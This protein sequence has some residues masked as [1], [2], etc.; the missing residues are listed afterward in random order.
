MAQ[1]PTD[2]P[3]HDGPHR[4]SAGAAAEPA[5]TVR[6]PEPLVEAPEVVGEFLGFR[7][8]R[9][10][11]RGAF[12]RVYLARQADLADRPVVLKVSPDVADE[13][14]T[15]AQLRHPN[16]VPVYSV[17]RAPPLQAVCMPYLGETT[18]A[19]VL[20]LSSNRWPVASGR[21]LVETI[22]SLACEHWPLAPPQGSRALLEKLAGLTYVNAV[23][24][25]VARLADGLA[26]AH[27][28]GILHRDLKPANILLSD[29]GQP[30]LL[31]FN[32]AEDTKRRRG[33]GRPRGGTLP[34]MA[35]E[36]LGAFR[37]GRVT[38]APTPAPRGGGAIDGRSD[39]YALG[40][41][42]YELLA[43]RPPFPGRAEPR[44]DLIER[45]LRDRA[46]SPP[47]LRPWNPAVT[48][49]IEAVV[50]RCLEPDPNRRYRSA[51]KLQEEL[52]RQLTPQPRGHAPE[53]S[54]RERGGKVG[55]HPRQVLSGGP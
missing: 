54:L 14:R 43:G 6:L 21:W 24:W 35:P 30:M 22:A 55:R 33:R 16:I 8:L 32:L 10:L 36:Q 48:L 19:D 40:V 46:G 44:H 26:H 27:A 52:E 7:V 47:Y 23:V 49:A 3:R 53:P 39:V 51:R 20:R 34:Y 4:V 29:E 17:H 31:D 13:A 9:P 38:A 15:L 12:S 45:M 11:A 2:G 18:L 25:I 41:V 37:S 1:R 28:H 5:V 42:L 50:R